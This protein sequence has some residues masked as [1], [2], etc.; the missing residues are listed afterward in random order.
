[1]KKM[2][3]TAMFTMMAI[4]LCCIASMTVFAVQNTTKEILSDGQYGHVDGYN[5]T[6]LPSAKPLDEEQKSQIKK[7]YM[8]YESLDVPEDDVN[9][10]Y[11]GTL[12]DGSY[13]TTTNYKYS[14]S[15][16]GIVFYIMNKYIYV[17][18]GGGMD[19]KIYK[20]HSFYNIFEM[21]MSNNLSIDMLDEI[22]EVLNFETYPE[23]SVIDTTE[24]SS[25]ALTTTENVATTSEN[26]TIYQNSTATTQYTEVTT[27]ATD[28]QSSTGEQ[29]TTKKVATNDVAV[30]S[31]NQNNS[32]NTGSNG[33]M[34][35]VLLII[36]IAFL[37]VFLRVNNKE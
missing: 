5:V 29:A 36:S 27:I 2:L 1:M 11:Y 31:N 9:L 23:K 22:A 6:K 21:Y 16:S 4:A 8:V 14:T 26:T 35:V 24:S 37:G 18:P 19:V 30:N 12:S 32:V 20:N 34:F 15:T 13:L 33:I 7:D 10:D 28:A 17:V 3:K 25:S